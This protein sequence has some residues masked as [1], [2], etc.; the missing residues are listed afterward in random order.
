MLSD[1]ELMTGFPTYTEYHR[2][3]TCV[4]PREMQRRADGRR[5]QYLLDL[6]YARRIVEYAIKKDWAF[7]HERRA[8]SPDPDLPF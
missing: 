8:I 5:R 2:Y 6:G 3:W 4:Q 7:P 1:F